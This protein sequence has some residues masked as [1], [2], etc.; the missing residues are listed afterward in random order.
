MGAS[1]SYEDMGKAWNYEE[2]YYAE[3]CDFNPKKDRAQLKVVHQ[4]ADDI[5]SGFLRPYQDKLLPELKSVVH[6][7][8]FDLL[9]TPLHTACFYG[10]SRAV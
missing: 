10:F 7:F 9:Q 8:Y 2:N 6:S 5:V 3:N 1:F 4:T